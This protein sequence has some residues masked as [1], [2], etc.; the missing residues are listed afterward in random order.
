MHRITQLN[1]FFRQYQKNQK[2]SIKSVLDHIGRTGINR[3]S[4]GSQQKIA[5]MKKITGK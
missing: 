4:Y 3:E 2:K 1:N 5:L